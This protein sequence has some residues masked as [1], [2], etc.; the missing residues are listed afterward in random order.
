M[1]SPASRGGFKL[2]FHLR[3]ASLVRPHPMKIGDNVLKV[4][5]HTPVHLQTLERAYFAQGM[6]QIALLL[7]GDLTFD[8][9]NHHEARARSD[10]RNL[11]HGHRWVEY[12]RASLSFDAHDLRS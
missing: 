7:I 4:R 9:S 12:R 8:E 10:R 6:Q 2:K 5:S 1:F 11:M 3:D